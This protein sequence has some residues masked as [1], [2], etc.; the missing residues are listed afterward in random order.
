MKTKKIL[1]VEDELLSAKYLKTILEKNNFL[2]IDII[3]TGKQAIQTVKR[4][5]P[6]LILLDVMLKDNISG[7]EV[8]EK[9]ESF[10][11]AII[12]FLSAYDDEEMLEYALKVDAYSYLMKPYRDAEIIM[13]VKMALNHQNKERQSAEE[14]KSDPN[15]VHLCHGYIFNKKDNI[16]SKNNRDIYLG[17][18]GILLVKLLC[19]NINHI[20]SNEQICRYIYQ[21]DINPNTLKSLVRRVRKVTDM[22]LIKNINSYGYKIESKERCSN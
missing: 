7:C 16:L 22:D 4:L 6:D 17:D 12:I 8:A 9:I 20:V 2:V 3:E 5:Q 10:S 18:K 19:E 11:D 21:K 1:I 14:N 13:T 15:L